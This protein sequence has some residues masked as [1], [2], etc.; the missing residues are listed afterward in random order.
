M[1]H[2]GDAPPSQFVLV[3]ADEIQDTHES[4]KS[5]IP[6]LKSKRDH[7][8]PLGFKND[9]YD[10][11]QHLKEMGGGQFIGVDGKVS[12]LPAT[13]RIV[14]LPSDALPSGGEFDRHLEAITISNEFMDDDLRE[15]LFGE[16]DEFEELAD[17]F[18]T[19]AMEE[20]ETPDFDYEAHIAALI[21]KSE[22]VVLGECTAAR[23]WSDEDEDLS[24]YEGYDENEVYEQPGR[25]GQTGDEIEEHKK[26]IEEQ[27]EKTLETYGDEDIGD[28][29]DEIDAEEMQGT[30]DF[31][32]NNELLES[33]LDEFLQGS[34]DDQLAEGIITYTKGSRTIDESNNDLDEVELV[35]KVQEFIIESTEEIVSTDQIEIERDLH[36]MMISQEYLR[37]E[38]VQDQW[39]CETIL[40]TYSTLDNHP[41]IIQKERKKKKNSMNDQS[42]DGSS[43]FYSR[44]KQKTGPPQP[45]LLGGKYM[46]PKETNPNIIKK[47][48]E[49]KKKLP[50]IESGSESES[51]SES[52]EEDEEELNPNNDQIETVKLKREKP[53]TLRQKETPEEKKQRKAQVK[54]ERKEKRTSKKSLKSAFK[55]EEVRIGRIAGQSQDIDRVSV[56]RY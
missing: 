1:A 6:S 17:D 37:E 27:F 51:E 39:D 8:T 16:T 19:T 25:P 55:D 47:Q 21:A 4:T 49:K 40:S 46:L 9:G 32:D 3:K 20:P 7:I 12:Q 15:A 53:K 14:E 48:N 28:L 50:Q 18:M 33:A 5:S 42:S 10:Y 41:S 56:F 34:R 44:G 35:K 31:D 30:I 2:L 23:G 22:G 26:T 13:A 11:S 38:K 24:S 54:Q 52:D 29:E 36:E 45:I 43:G